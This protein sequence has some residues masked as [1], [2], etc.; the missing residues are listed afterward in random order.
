MAVEDYIEGELIESESGS[1]NRHAAQQN[2]MQVR[3]SYATAVSVQN[4][5]SLQTV[6]RNL[7]RESALAGASFYYGWSVGRDKVE[8]PSIGLAMAAA[9]CWGNCAIEQ[10]PMQET[11]DSWVFTA[12]FVDLETGFT[13]SRQFRQSKRWTVA[14]K[15]DAERKDDI[16]FQIGQS[17]AARNVIL[18]ALPEWLV[19]KAM[20]AA[21][22]GVREKIEQLIKDRGLPAAVDAAVKALAKVGVSE[23]A[24][25]DKCGV[26]AVTALDVDHLVILKGDLTAIQ[27]GQER[28]EA[29]FP[30]LAG[31]ESDTS[32]RARPSNVSELLGTAKSD[33]T[34]QGP[35]SEAQFTGI[36]KM[37][38]ANLAACESLGKVEESRKW[39]KK[40]A[41]SFD[42]EQLAEIDIR[43]DQARDSIKS[44]RGAG[45]NAKQGTLMDTHE[46]AGQ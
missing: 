27:S 13:L 35:P 10:L 38:D 45:S 29:L 20:E 7:E 3:G 16:R 8:G 19:D 6:T 17:K 25:L 22:A 36:L 33:D 44:S 37:L 34:K 11:P 9:R 4:P 12:I 2:M 32:K 18:K 28:P 30:A 41:P 1:A 42:D 39:A 40:Q 31:T 15:A 21:K 24:V 14:G 5:R 46:Q 43:C 26:A 23:A